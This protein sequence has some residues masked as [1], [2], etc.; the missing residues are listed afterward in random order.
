MGIHHPVQEGDNGVF[1][2]DPRFGLRVD[3]EGHVV[4]TLDVHEVVVEAQE[5]RG[6]GLLA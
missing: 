3:V 6:E 1:K 5:G 4:V 2:G